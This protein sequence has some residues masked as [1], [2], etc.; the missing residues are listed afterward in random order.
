MK[1]C[2]K[3][4]GTYPA[5]FS[6]CPQDGTPLRTITELPEGTVIRGK[7]RILSK[8]GEGGMG[9]VYK[10]RHVR[11]DE[12]WALKLVSTSLLEDPT[13]LQ[14]FNAEAVLMRK[15]DHPNAL[16]V[17]DIDETEDGR[18]FIVM[19]YVEGRDLAS[20]LG[21]GPM[22]PVRAARI[23]MQACAALGAAHRLG[24]IH[25]DIKPTNI[26][27]SRAADGSEHAKVFDF[28]IAKV[29]EGGPL[30]GAS[31][32][33][34]GMIVGTPVYM[35]P[36]QAQGLRGE[37]LDGRTDL[38]SLGIVLYEMLTGSVPFT[39]ETPMQLLFAHVQNA[40]PDP[41]TIRA[42]LPAALAEIVLRALEKDPAKRFAS[43]EET[44]DALAVAVADLEALRNAQTR[45]QTPVPAFSPVATARVATPQPTPA[46][47]PAE[48]KRD[49]PIPPVLP[50]STDRVVTP[51][52]S[53]P[54][55]QRRPVETQPQA[56]SPSHAPRAVTK[57]PPLE[58]RAELFRVNMIL[59]SVVVLVLLVVTVN[60]REM[61]APPP[62]SAP[63]GSTAA[64]VPDVAARRGASTPAAGA[65]RESPG[66]GLNYVWIPA[67]TFLMGCSQGDTEC[68]PDEK[69]PHQVTLTRGFWIGQTEVTVAAYRRFATA[70]GRTMPGAPN[71]NT[72]WANEN[73]PILNVS[74]DDAQ[75][76]CGWAGG[77]L[78]T[79]AEWEYAARGGSS[80]A[81]YGGIADVAWYDANSGGQTRDVAQKRPN[82]FG[83][84][85]TL[86]N[87]WEWV[88]DWYDEN[89]YRNS[90]SQ[91]PRGPSSGQYRV[92]RGG[93]WVN[94]AWVVRASDRGRYNPE[95]W[96]YVHGFRC[97]REVTSP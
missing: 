46:P 29:K 31:L 68:D 85:D 51:P 82:G 16:R 61:S 65:V 27:V 87:V 90:P 55:A 93:S 32:T 52:P 25:R 73:M 39:G 80:E 35:S 13:F 89:Y 69:P 49:T 12:V 21:D 40:P 26:M 94:V 3:C 7:Y 24:I 88:N 74:W 37:K 96:N 48:T 19:E 81:R 36:E 59:G 60:R 84:Y 10:A 23:V 30:G 28:G 20:L 34:T 22:E 41:R 18:P 86:G 95:N 70:V 8:L 54:E 45:V 92:L 83:L 58:P 66:D 77:R 79:E 11:F 9:V 91:D 72:G 64:P 14:R 4:Q 2:P 42:E 5:H 47:P 38:Y 17:H 75:A 71:F 50:P 78:P 76:Y 97:V 6:M 43:G 62:T 67:G 63:A 57:A 1:T 44:R 33:Q 53:P 56:P 15:L